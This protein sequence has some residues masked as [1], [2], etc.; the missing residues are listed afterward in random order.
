ME[1]AR[2]FKRLD[3]RVKP[4]HDGKREDGRVRRCRYSH[5][6]D[7]PYRRRSTRRAQSR[8]PARQIVLEIVDVFEPD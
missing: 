3:G 6:E 1:P 4:G 5:G 2:Q 8:K 7:A